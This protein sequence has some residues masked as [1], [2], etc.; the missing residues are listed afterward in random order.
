LAFEQL[1]LL[2]KQS[3]NGGDLPR[4]EIKAL[5]YQLVDIV[6]QFGLVGRQRCIQE[7]FYEP[8]R[9]RALAA[10]S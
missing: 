1:T 4:P 3:R 7:V 5:L 2:V 9:K 8:A 10:R 6:V